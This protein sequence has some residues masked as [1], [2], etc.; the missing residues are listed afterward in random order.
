MFGLVGWQLRLLW[1][2]YQVQ[3]FGVRLK[4]RLMLMFGVIVVLFGV[5]VYGVLVQFVMCFIESWF[6]VCVEKVL[7]LGLYFGCLVFD[8]MLVD[9]I[10]KSWSIVTGKQIGRA[11]V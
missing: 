4:L 2:D 7:E 3:V 9:L 11:H 6:D 1:C 10:E 5:L 8:V